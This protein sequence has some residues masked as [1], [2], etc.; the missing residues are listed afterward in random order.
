MEEKEKE[1]IFILTGTYSV[2]IQIH[3]HMNIHIHIL[4][5]NKI[6][7][8]ERREVLNLPTLEERRVRGNMLAT[9]KFLNGYHD[10]NIVL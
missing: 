3:T 4:E 1:W 10:V 2:D 6:S 7:H 5:V 9:Y 8:E